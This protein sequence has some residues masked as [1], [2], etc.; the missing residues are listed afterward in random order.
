LS[1]DWIIDVLTDLHAY[2]VL[3]GMDALAKQVERTLDVARREIAAKAEETRE[4]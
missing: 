1:H 2:A 3:N 4:G